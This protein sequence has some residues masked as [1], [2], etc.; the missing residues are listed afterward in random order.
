[1]TNDVN[2]SQLSNQELGKL[3]RMGVPGSQLSQSALLELI[4]RNKALRS[5]L[6]HVFGVVP[7]HASVESGLSQDGLNTNQLSRKKTLSEHLNNGWLENVSIVGGSSIILGII[8]III[9]GISSSRIILLL[10]FLLG[11]IAFTSF[12]LGR[13]IIN[14]SSKRTKVLSTIILGILFVLFLYLLSY[15]IPT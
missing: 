9:I 13:I 12:F 3:V 1:M 11:I 4:G 5:E 2:L 6:E 10:L 7:S 14:S 15:L 8:G